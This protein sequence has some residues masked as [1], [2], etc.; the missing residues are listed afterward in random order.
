VE[1]AGRDFRTTGFRIVLAILLASVAVGAWWMRLRSEARLQGAANE[2]HAWTTLRVL[3][4]DAAHADCTPRHG[5][6]FKALPVHD[7]TGFAFCAYP[8]D[9]PRS[10]KWT[11]VINE[12]KTLYRV[13]TRG[14]PIQAWAP[15][16]ATWKPLD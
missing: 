15:D 1:Q 9:Y 4:A 5:Y 6:Y 8:A 3:A 2:R 16:P 11:F 12:S 14:E 13:D 10:G 7:R